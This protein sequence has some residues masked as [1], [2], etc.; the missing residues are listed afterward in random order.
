VERIHDLYAR[1]EAY[2][3]QQHVNNN[4]L[5]DIEDIITKDDTDVII[6]KQ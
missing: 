2:T 1:I 4:T 3:E 6:V 5:I